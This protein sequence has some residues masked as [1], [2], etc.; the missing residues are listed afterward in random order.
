MGKNIKR[1]FSTI[2]VRVFYPA[3]SL[4]I[5]L[6]VYAAN[7][8]CCL[9][10]YLPDMQKSNIDLINSIIDVYSNS[11]IVR[12]IVVYLFVLLV[13]A[14]L[15][16]LATRFEYLSKDTS[17]KE[18]QIDSLE[19]AERSYMPIYLSY[20]FVALSFK[21]M[22]SLC[23]GFAIFYVL[24]LFTEAMSFN[25]L[26]RI[27]GYRFYNLKNTAGKQIMII[28]KMDKQKNSTAKFDNLRRINEYTYYQE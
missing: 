12:H 28:V 23:I 25:P 24:S 11:C 14:F 4:S 8:I 18:Y 13:M 16:F 2:S 6:L 5:I 17:E 7:N 20:F 1:I 21:S 27:M 9:T 22:E 3:S 19:P 10:K 26:L 15:L